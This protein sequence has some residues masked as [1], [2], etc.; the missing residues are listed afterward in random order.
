MMTV[1]ELLKVIC[2]DK[3][4]CIFNTIG[5]ATNHDS[6][7]LIRNIGLGRKQFYMRVSKMIEVGLVVKY[8]RRYNLTTLGKIVYHVQVVIGNALKDHWKLKALD[9]LNVSE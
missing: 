9:V 8:G 5:L 2:D 7:I 1:G 3:S 6:D 4:L